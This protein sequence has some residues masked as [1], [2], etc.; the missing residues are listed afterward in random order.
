MALRNGGAH[1]GWRVH[2]AI[3]KIDKDA[4]APKKEDL[5]NLR[6]K[7]H[8]DILDE[9]TWLRWTNSPAPTA[10]TSAVDQEIIRCDSY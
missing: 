6:I 7:I 9:T 2:Q 5:K 4:A 8:K 10:K 1:A 3:A